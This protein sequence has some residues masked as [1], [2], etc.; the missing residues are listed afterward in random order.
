M[1]VLP[2]F[3]LFPSS[4][5]I[6]GRQFPGQAQAATHDMASTQ[7]AEGERAERAERVPSRARRAMNLLMKAN[8]EKA[9][10]DR[11][12]DDVDDVGWNLFFFWVALGMLGQM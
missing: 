10:E 11:D 12:V 4:R 7:P 1:G 6:C 5:G 9:I 2:L 8:N 3:L